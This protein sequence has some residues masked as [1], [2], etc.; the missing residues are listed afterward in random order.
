MEIGDKF[1][2]ASER[3]ER[4]TLSRSSMGNVICIYISV[5]AKKK[6]PYIT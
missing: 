5:G 1:L 2:L 4:D 6:F 3:S